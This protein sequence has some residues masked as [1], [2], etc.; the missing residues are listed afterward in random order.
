MIMKIIRQI[1]LFI[2][3]LVLYNA[4][5]FMS[6]T[7]TLDTDVFNVTLISGAAV[8]FSINDL[9]VVFGVI[10]L[11]IEI[12]KATKTSTASIIDHA[13]SMIVFIVFLVEFIVISELGTATFLILMLMSLLD[14]VAG[15]TVTISTA[16]RDLELD[17]F[18]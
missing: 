1:P 9:M 14:V 16:R 7:L 12:L 17:R 18:S 6:T 13:L 11:F 2:G 3:V 4:L 5:S 15:F 10:V 8:G